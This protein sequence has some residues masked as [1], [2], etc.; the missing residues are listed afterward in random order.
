MCLTVSSSLSDLDLLNSTFFRGG[1]RFQHLFMPGSIFW[2]VFFWGEVIFKRNLLPFGMN[3]TSKPPPPPIVGTIFAKQL[4][5]GVQ[6]GLT[7]RFFLCYYSKTMGVE[8][9]P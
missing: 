4:F 1:H 6:I 7:F 8:M 3:T 5:F 2:T 9:D